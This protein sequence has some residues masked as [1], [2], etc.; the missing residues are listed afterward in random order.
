LLKSCEIR[1]SIDIHQNNNTI[2]STKIMHGLGYVVDF[3]Q[4]AAIDYTK[5]DIGKTIIPNHIYKGVVFD[6]TEY[7]LEH[8]ITIEDSKCRNCNK[9]GILSRCSRCKIAKYC[10]KECQTHDYIYHK[11]DC[12]DGKLKKENIR[13]V[14]VSFYDENTNERKYTTLKKDVWECFIIKH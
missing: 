4:L 7:Q 8:I 2:M 10:S 5:K 3:S 12:I 1:K 11:R 14:Y 13:D 6:R 9:T